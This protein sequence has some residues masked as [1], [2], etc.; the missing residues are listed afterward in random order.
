MYTTEF[1][2]CQRDHAA[3]AIELH[4]TASKR[5]HCMH[6]RKILVLKVVNV[7]QHLGFG[8][9]RI[10]NRMMEERCSSAEVLRNYGI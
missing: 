10:K 2:P 6:E 7:A 3:R 5:N 9:V 4:G 1:G 8:V